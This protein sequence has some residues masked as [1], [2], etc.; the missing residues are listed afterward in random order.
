MTFPGSSTSVHPTQ[1]YEMVLDLAAFVLVLWARK[2]LRR[3]WDLF[4]LSLASYG[5]IRFVMEFFRVHADP[6][7][8]LFFQLVSAALFLFSC[9]MLFFRERGR[10]MEGDV[11]S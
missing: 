10:P 8:A 11:E 9:T 3:D 4:L 1:L 6:N 5:L 2:R 7:A